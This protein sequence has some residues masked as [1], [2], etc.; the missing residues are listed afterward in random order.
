MNVYVMDHNFTI[1][2]VIDNYI[3]LIWTQRY[4]QRGD[5]EI[6]VKASKENLAILQKGFY[7]IREKDMGSAV[8]SVMIVQNITVQTD[9]ENGDN[10]IVSGHDAKD[11]IHRRV[12][13][14]Q[15]VF[16]NQSL[17]SIVQ[18]LL[19]THIISASGD[20]KISCFA[21]DGTPSIG[22]TDMIT[23]QITGDNLGEYIEELLSKYGYG[24]EVYYHE[25]CFYFRLTDGVDRSME[26]NINQYVIFSENF[27]NLLSSSYQEDMSDFASFAYVA[28]EGEGSDRKIRG[29]GSGAG[30]DRYEL[31]V[32][33]RDISSNDG[34]ITTSEYNSMLDARGGESLAEHSTTVY[35]EGN[36]NDTVNY[37]LGVDYK[38]GDIV[39]VVT[40]YGI[41]LPARIA[42]IIESDDINGEQMIPT[43]EYKGGLS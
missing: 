15:T 19:T 39:Q 22:A 3:S 14:A 21:F 17:K 10:L 16:N 25:A 6:M 29:I 18:S 9:V 20:R 33:A 7:L 4:N 28:G 2:Y 35:F 27:D 31:W 24:Y 11:I 38:L 32:D 1:Q 34:E 43:F 42:E 26:Q 41:S 30:L 23:V 37:T 12:I 13:N 40:D 5:F 36:V 8:P